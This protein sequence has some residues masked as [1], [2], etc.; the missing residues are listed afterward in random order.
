MGCNPWGFEWHFPRGFLRP[1]K[2]TTAAKLQLCNSKENNFIV[3]GYQNMRKIKGHRV[4]KV[5]N[6]HFSR[7]WQGQ[8]QLLNNKDA[9]WRRG[10]IL[11]WP[12]NA[13]LCSYMR[14]V[15]I[16]LPKSSGWSPLGFSKQNVLSNSH[17]TAMLLETVLKS[18][19]WRR[20]S[21]RDS[22]RRILACNSQEW[23]D[24]LK[25]MKLGLL[26]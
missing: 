17:T 20:N 9:T 2:S 24:F 10:E 18:G 15:S 6:C 5:E 14:E 22:D 11:R 16:L 12:P 13:K 26:S 4:R 3:G 25:A 21:G 23:W 7:W 1:L 19:Q 8:P